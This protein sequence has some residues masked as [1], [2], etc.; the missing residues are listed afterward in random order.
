MTVPLNAQGKLAAVYKA[1]GGTT[2]LVFDVTG[3]FEPGTGHARYV[4]LPVRA[5]DTRTGTGLSDGKPAKLVVSSPLSLQVRGV[6]GVPGIPAEAVAI[7]GNLTVTGQT[8][9]GYLAITTD[10]TSTPLTSSL[11][12]P[13]GDDRANGF[14]A[15]L[16]ASGQIS[17]VYKAAAGTTDVV[18]DI[19]GYFTSAGERA[20]L[21]PAQPGPGHG[22]PGRGG[23]QRAE[24]GLLG[25]RRP[26]PRDR[27]PL[28]RA[29]RC[30]GDHRQPDRDRPDG[31]RLRLDDPRPDGQPAHLDPQLPTGRCPGQRPV[32]TAQRQR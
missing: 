9:A 7:S 25:Q 10:P 2:D 19:T 24:R 11:N 13:L 20:G 28:G 16:S 22:H 30:R 23:Q 4:S 26:D 12:F 3:Y 32:R 18:V 29:G 1:G 31:R 17:I 6:G 15:Q 21:L 14:T 5:L 8:K 27:R